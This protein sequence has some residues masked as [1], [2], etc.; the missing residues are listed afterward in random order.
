MAASPPKYIQFTSKDLQQMSPEAADA[1]AEAYSRKYYT[2]SDEERKQRAPGVVAANVQQQGDYGR[3][4]EDAQRQTGYSKE[5]QALAKTQ[6]AQGGKL[7]E[8][9]QKQFDTAGDIPPE[10]LAA[11]TRAGLGDATKAITGN[12]TP[13]S[14]GSSGVA[15]H[16]GRDALG[17]AQQ[18]RAEALATMKA[19][20]EAYGLA[21]T[22][23]G[24]S[25]QTGGLSNQTQQ[26]A[27]QSLALS[28][29]LNPSRSFGLSGADAVGLQKSNL[30]TANQVNQA[31]VQGRNQYRSSIYASMAAADAAAAKKKSGTGS[32]IGSIAG[33]IIGSV[34]PG[35]GT[36]I[37]SAA[38]GAIG[39]MFG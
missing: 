10:I 25:N 16:L 32:L 26:S 6:A 39:G 34:V 15:R 1:L 27:D 3:G 9:G 29:E 19:G 20:N 2:E 38:G 11:Y 31:N 13:G 14:I 35:I 4:V 33:G 12:I 24:T 8:M 17:Y 22:T 7:W 23:F 28:N 30:D 18:R 36:M 5:Q 21:D 37:G